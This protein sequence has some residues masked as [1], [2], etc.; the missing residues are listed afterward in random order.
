MV[1]LYI[2]AFSIYDMKVDKGNWLC[3]YILR[4]MPFF[5]P[6]INQYELLKMNF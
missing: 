1:K 5:M 3:I 6:G 4:M 2:F